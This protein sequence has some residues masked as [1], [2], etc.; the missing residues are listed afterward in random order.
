MITKSTFD[1]E[2][3]GGIPSVTIKSH[4]PRPLL[5]RGGEG[6]KQRNET[7]TELSDRDKSQHDTASE[8]DDKETQHSLK[9]KRLEGATGT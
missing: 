7:S 4:V 2:G 8:W 6:G 5:R 9:K 1:D 3:N